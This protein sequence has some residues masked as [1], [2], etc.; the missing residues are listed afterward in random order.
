MHVLESSPHRR[1]VRWRYLISL[2]LFSGLVQLCESRIVRPD[3]YAYFLTDEVE[4]S[5]ID[6]STTGTQ[7]LQNSDD[8]TEK[9]E[10][11]F[12]VNYATPAN[13]EISANGILYLTDANSGSGFSLDEV[14]NKDM[15]W[16]TPYFSHT[17]LFVYWDDLVTGNDGIF[18]ETR[19]ISGSREFIVQWQNVY[20]KGS[21]DPITFQV[22]VREFDGSI[23]FNYLN[24]DTGD[25]SSRGGSATIGAYRSSEQSLIWSYNEAS[26]EN[27]SSISL[28]QLQVPPTITRSPES[29]TL[30]QG[31]YAFFYMVAEGT[32]PFSYEW[33]IDGQLVPEFTDLYLEF[34][35][36]VSELGT[37]GEQQIQVTVSN[38]F[39]SAQSEIATF[40]TTEGLPSELVYQDNVEQ[41]GPI[42]SIFV[43]GNNLFLLDDERLWAYDASDPSTLIELGSIQVPNTSGEVRIHNNVAYINGGSL[44]FSTINVA[45]PE[46]MV[47]LANVDIPGANSGLDLEIIGDYAYLTVDDSNFHIIGIADP[48]NPRHIGNYNPEQQLR[49]IGISNNRA[50]LTSSQSDTPGLT[51]LDIS[52]P[53]SISLITEYYEDVTRS[54][55]VIA[56]DDTLYVATHSGGTKILD[57]SD[58]NNILDLGGPSHRAWYIDKVGDRIT[59]RGSTGDLWVYDTSDPIDLET[60]GTYEE[61]LFRNPFHING[62][63]AYTR[64]SSGAVNIYDLSDPNNPQLVGNTNRPEDIISITRHNGYTYALDASS[65]LYIYDTHQPEQTNRVATIQGFSESSKIAVA[66]DHLVTLTTDGLNFFGLTNPSN[67]VH[68]NSYKDDPLTGYNNFVPAGNYIYTINWDWIKT[69]DIGNLSSPNVTA[70]INLQ[71]SEFDIHY[72]D[73]RLFTR[74]DIYDVSQPNQINLEDPVFPLSL[75]FTAIGH[76]IFTGDSH[77]SVIDTNLDSSDSFIANIRMP[78]LSSFTHYHLSE[79]HVFTSSSDTIF[80]ID[81]SRPYDP[82]ISGIVS[83]DGTVPKDLLFEDGYL[84]VAGGFSGYRIFKL[85]VTSSTS[86]LDEWQV[87][88]F[89][90]ERFDRSKYANLWSTFADPDNDGVENS[91]EFLL[92]G[93]PNT[94]DNP[95]PIESFD[96]TQKRVQYRLRKSANHSFELKFLRSKDLNNWFEFTPEEISR[97]DHGEFWQIEVALPFDRFEFYRYLVI[98][99]ELQ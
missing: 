94:K 38:E 3:R 33:T 26:L 58:P 61:R 68:V 22:V 66:K 8:G 85:E 88:H 15:R 71:S 27:Q 42:A 40:E 56:D 6:I 48:S 5:F 41:L 43:S 2:T 72:A 20:R 75:P 69:I 12:Q 24:L 1:N 81:V 32:P 16:E 9:I 14:P 83:L 49:N 54:R 7:V 84:H 93:D 65:D 60:I 74:F 73:G 35:R 25:D 29:K 52:S 76:Y 44:G 53:Q 30:V 37:I 77:F 17:G 97:T 67:P 92:M 82:K 13:Y 23:H 79:E 87:I 98:G 51:I 28:Q 80:H 18:Y 36:S 11:P 91:A 59:A 89:G 47:E 45:D 10:A 34:N 86:D 50:F 55:D 95:F 63:T 4:F 19:G 46:N 64:D 99:G 96:N 78:T 39:G 57:V 62:T 31:S 90:N 21:P 70:S